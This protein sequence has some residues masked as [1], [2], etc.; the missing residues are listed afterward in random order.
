ME[1]AETL[2]HMGLG[3]GGTAVG[4]QLIGKELIPALGESAVGR[5]GTTAGTAIL[6]STVLGLIGGSTL[7]ARALTGGLLATLWQILTEVLPKPVTKGFIPVPG[8]GQAPETEEFRR[9]IEQEVL[10]ELRGGA[11]MYLPPAGQS[12]YL[13]E[14]EAAMARYL[15]PAGQSAYLTAQ[16]AGAGGATPDTFDEFYSA[17]APERF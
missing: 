2:F 1:S 14:R 4:S 11:E 9:A 8:M 5:V 17:G 16:E 3:F 10:R 7:A 12:A 6:G 15:P 13:T